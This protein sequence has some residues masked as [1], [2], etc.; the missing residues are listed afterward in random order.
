LPRAAPPPP[1]PRLPK[2]TWPFRL[3]DSSSHSTFPHLAPALP[4]CLGAG[5]KASFDA[6]REAAAGENDAK[7]AKVEK[8]IEKQR[9][10][11]EDAGAHPSP[12]AASASPAHALPRH[13]PRPRLA[14]EWLPRLPPPLPL[15]PTPT[16]RAHP[17]LPPTPAAAT[18]GAKSRGPD[19]NKGSSG[20]QGST[21]NTGDANKMPFDLSTMVRVRCKHG[22]DCKR[23]DGPVM[24]KWRFTNDGKERKHFVC[25]ACGAA[26]HII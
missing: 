1:P 12:A 20:A 9:K 11:K 23:A 14:W 8:K 4:L 15:G 7:K 13:R 18:A 25:S 22:E 6:Q 3:T 16:T 19:S 21:T 26:A 2:A 10:Q 24:A 5:K 17:R